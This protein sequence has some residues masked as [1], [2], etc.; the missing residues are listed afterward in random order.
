MSEARWRRRLPDMGR[1]LLIYAAGDTTAALIQGRFVL[2]RMLGVMAVGAL[3]YA[4]E[5]PAYFRW[6]DRRTAAVVSPGRRALGRTALALLYFNPLWITR[7]LFFLAFFA[8]R[9]AEIGWTLFR[10]GALSWLFNIPLSAAGNYLIQVRLPLRWRFTASAV[11]SA[12][13]AVYYAL[14]L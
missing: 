7:H 12:L 6:I 10:S 9:W 14:F 4:M 11:F 1:G 3:I 13:M 5:I 8:G 2:G